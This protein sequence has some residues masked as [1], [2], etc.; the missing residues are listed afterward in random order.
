MSSANEK[1]V[2]G[3][4]WRGSW[5]GVGDQRSR[6]VSL[7]LNFKGFKN[8]IGIQGMKKGRYKKIQGTKVGKLRA[9][10]E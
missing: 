4:F 8:W 2:T 7:M 9:L 10:S 1:T 5:E 6:I 3:S